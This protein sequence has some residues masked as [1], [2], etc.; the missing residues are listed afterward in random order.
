MKTYLFTLTT[1][2][3]S[4]CILAACG[5]IEAPQGANIIPITKE[6]LHSG[7]DGYGE[8]KIIILKN[9]LECVR[10]SSG[11]VG[12]ISCNWQ[13]WNEE[14]RFG[15]SKARKLLTRSEGDE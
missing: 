11:N 13:K 6:Y 2:V 14:T 4:A 3:L 12:G 8:Y 15:Y 7:K 9:G 10:L 1:A 5:E